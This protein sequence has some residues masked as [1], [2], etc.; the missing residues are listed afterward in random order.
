M[1]RMKGHEK[2]LPVLIMTCQIESEVES[3]NENIS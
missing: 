2:H 3:E 1:E